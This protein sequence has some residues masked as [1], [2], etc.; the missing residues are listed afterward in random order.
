MN[1]DL[2]AVPMDGHEDKVDAV[3]DFCLAWNAPIQLNYKGQKLVLMPYDAYLDRF[4]TP[5]ER[6]QLLKSL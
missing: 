5:E 4:C 3:L 6:E 1:E 2:P